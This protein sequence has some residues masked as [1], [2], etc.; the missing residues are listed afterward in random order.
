M[1]RPVLV[2]S[3]TA[4]K[5]AEP[6]PHERL[7]RAAV[8]LSAVMARQE[9]EVHGFQDNIAE[10]GESIRQLGESMQELNAR[11]GRINWR[12]LRRRSLRL[13][14]IMENWEQTSGVTPGRPRT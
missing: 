6:T 1:A 2:P 12:G 14:A 9:R 11:M 13:V 3:S 4:E 5:T 8:A 10:L 7:E